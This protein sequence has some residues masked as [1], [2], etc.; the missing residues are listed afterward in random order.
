MNAG[1]ATQGD[2]WLNPA[3][4]K[5][6]REWRGRTIEEAAAKLKKAPDVI[7]GWEQSQGKPTV[8]QARILADFYDRSF[9]E[10]FLSEPP[11]LHEPEV[12]PDF[13]M[14]AGITAPDRDRETKLIHQ[15]AQTQRVNALDLYEELGE[16][17]S[18]IPPHLFATLNSDPGDVA[19][20]V[21]E[22]VGFS[23][24]AQINLRK[25]GIDELPKILRR[26]LETIGV[27][28]L[29]HG[30]L[31]MLGIRGICLAVFPLPVIV[32]HNEAP[33]AQAFTLMHEL[34]HVLTKKSGIT[35]PRRTYYEHQ[36]V[37]QWCDRFAA[38]FLMPEQAVI[39]LYGER[40]KRPAASIED[41]DLERLA[42]IFRVSPHAMLI[43]LVYLGHVEA[44]YYW[45]VK[46]P[47][48]DSV[49]NEYRPFGRSRFYGR[50]YQTSL[51][52]LYTG[53]VLEAW[54]AGRITSHN[55]A[56]Y[57]GIKKLDH[58]RDIRDEFGKS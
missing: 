26:T 19:N 4:L 41:A 25:S 27:L 47:Q 6:A 3:M 36:P 37:E 5:W 35:G 55:A 56:E 49:E 54:G 40:P 57:M 20:R 28:T 51:G 9:L 1:T 23:I 58:L 22:A 29:K 34:G 39:S 44:A 33:T 13:R 43:R 12:I 46:K 21:R 24:Q 18:E 2:L 42:D 31:K 38:S 17:P 30:G 50:R 7:E 11:T 52:D 15:W 53:L 10:F 32:F 48:F 14:H 8:R 16:E 45:D